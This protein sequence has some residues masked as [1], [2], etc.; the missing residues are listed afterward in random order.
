MDRPIAGLTPPVIEESKF[1][2][3]EEM[4]PIVT[5]TFA[6][7]APVAI[8]GVLA[9]PIVEAIDGLAID[10]TEIIVEPP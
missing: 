3:E 10:V 1:L 8:E 4:I 6:D 2:G 7:I 5:E 9:E